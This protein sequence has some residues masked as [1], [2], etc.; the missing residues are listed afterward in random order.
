VPGACGVWRTF[1]IP[2]TAINNSYCPRGAPVSFP[3]F[4]S[5][6]S[7]LPVQE[8]FM[9]VEPSSAAVL[10]LLAS[11]FTRRTHPVEQGH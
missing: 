2:E 9:F 7:N 10:A 3:V 5:N 1:L 4:S 8:L 6:F 11:L